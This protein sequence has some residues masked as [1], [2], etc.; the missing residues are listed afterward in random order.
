VPQE[1]CVP[2]EHFISELAKRNIIIND[3]FVD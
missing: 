2:A 3:Y 1:L